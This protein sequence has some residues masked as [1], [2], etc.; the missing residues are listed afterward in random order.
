MSKRRR[1]KLVFL[2][3]SINMSAA[4]GLTSPSFGKGGSSSSGSRGGGGGRV[5]TSRPVSL[6]KPPLQPSRPSTSAGGGGANRQTSGSFSGQGHQQL[7][8][9]Y[10]PTKLQSG[11]GSSVNVPG[12]GRSQFTA[13]KLR[14]SPPKIVQA[15]GGGIPNQSR[16]TTQRGYLNPSFGMGGSLPLFL[17]VSFFHHNQSQSHNSSSPQALPDRYQDGEFGA[18]EVNSLPEWIQASLRL[19]HS[20]KEGVF[21]SDITIEPLEGDDRTFEDQ[22]SNLLKEKRELE[23]SSEALSAV[24]KA[25]ELAPE[26][27]AKIK[28]TQVQ[29]DEISRAAQEFQSQADETIRLLTEAMQKKETL[30]ENAPVLCFFDWTCEH[31]VI[32]SELE[33]EKELKFRHQ[34]LLNQKIAALAN[35]DKLRVNLMAYQEELKKAQEL[36]RQNSTETEELY[37][38]KM[39][40]LEQLKTQIRDL[41]QRIEKQQGFIL[42]N[43]AAGIQDIPN[44]K[45]CPASQIFI[46]KISQGVTPKGN[47]LFKEAVADDIKP[48]PEVADLA[49]CVDESKR[50]KSI[51]IVQNKREIY[52]SKIERND[53]SNIS[54][55][56]ISN[57][58]NELERHTWTRKEE[59]II[60]YLIRF[61]HNNKAVEI[62]SD[63]NPDKIEIETEPTSN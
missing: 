5:S 14:A 58:D 6:S 24:I 55:L 62:Y 32:S 4:I 43:S 56:T 40:A 11:A 30:R 36:L 23:S 28:L 52:F 44:L 49:V 33:T 47:P 26:N 41:Q 9:T 8:P 10:V 17:W 60:R 51:H 38:L 48:R 12:T 25:F 2:F 19:M 21:P 27:E 20:Q 59:G 63:I 53:S 37:K 31:L 16:L 57:S 13:E 46:F 61:A 7:M 35:R 45:D 29:I 54:S 42:W 1:T 3:I 22:I 15:L 18:D 50:L 39:A 34:Y